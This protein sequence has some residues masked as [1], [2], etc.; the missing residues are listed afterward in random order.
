MGGCSAEREVSLRSGAAVAAALERLGYIV[1]RVDVTDHTVVLPEDIEAVFI[2]L[3][4]AFGEDGGV[5]RLLEERGIPY[6]GSG[7]HSSEAAFDKVC[8]K[9]ILSRYGIPT[10]TYE[11]LQPGQHRTLPLPVVTKPI[12]QGSSLGVHRVGTEEEWPAACESTRRYGAEILV[13]PYIAGRELTVGIV[14]GE[15]LP[16]IEICAPNGWYDYEAK[17]TPGR[18]LYHVPAPVSESMRRRCQDL[19]VA[20]FRAL[21]SRGFGRVDLRGTAED[22]LCVLES[23]TIPGFTETSL[24]PKAAAHA[25]I[26]FE[27][28]C[29][30]ILETAVCGQREALEKISLLRHDEAPNVGKAGLV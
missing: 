14:D 11:I 21:G 4:G 20:T 27:R 26:S 8:T 5:Q 17:Y 24:L 23:N 7:P 22:D 15:P 2:A 12:R 30:R 29:E 10:P 18:T 1:T 16:V 13:E 28:L 19:A 6:T 9:R 25:G 3:H